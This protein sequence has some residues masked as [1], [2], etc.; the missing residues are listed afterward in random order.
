M[1]DEFADQI[2]RI[3]TKVDRKNIQLGPAATESEVATFEQSAGVRLP[4]GFRE[5]LKQ[6]GNGGTGPPHYGMGCEPFAT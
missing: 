4:D 2:R 6:I 3:K 1:T 5:F